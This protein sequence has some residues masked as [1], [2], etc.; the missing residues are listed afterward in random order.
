MGV[1]LLVGVDPSP[2]RLWVI[3][4]THRGFSPLGLNPRCGGPPVPSEP[5]RIFAV[6][7]V[8]SVWQLVPALGAPFTGCPPDRDRP[9]RGGPGRSS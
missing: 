8:V 5:D 6:A 7:L 9:G 2:Q 3:P 4:S 1:I